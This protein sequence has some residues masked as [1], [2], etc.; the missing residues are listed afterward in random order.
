[1]LSR[2]QRRAPRV[3]VLGDAQHVELLREARRP[4]RDRRFVAD[5]DAPATTDAAVSPQ[6]L[7]RV[8]RGREQDGVVQDPE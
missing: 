6:P 3:L 5:H 1:M 2:K 4:L 7:A 8:G